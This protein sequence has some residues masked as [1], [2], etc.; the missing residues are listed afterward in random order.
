MGDEGD[1]GDWLVQ[2][3]S[4]QASQSSPLNSSGLNTVVSDENEFSLTSSEPI[5]LSSPLPSIELDDISFLV[6]GMPL[7]QVVYPVPIRE[8]TNVDFE[9]NQLQNGRLFADHTEVLL[10]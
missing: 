9:Q 3:S 7:D 10:N 2:S 5:D 8:S 1:C 6:D 4:M